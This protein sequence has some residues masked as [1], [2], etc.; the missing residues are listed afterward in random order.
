MNCTSWPRIISWH[1]PYPMFH[2][3]QPPTVFPHPICSNSSEALSCQ[4]KYWS[5]RWYL[6]KSPFFSPRPWTLEEIIF[7][8][9]ANSVRNL[10]KVLER[11]LCKFKK[12]PIFQLILKV[13][14]GLLHPHLELICHEHSFW[15]SLSQSLKL[16]QSLKEESPVCF[17]D[18]IFLNVSI[19]FNRVRTEKSWPRAREKV[20]KIVTKPDTKTN[21]I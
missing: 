6:Q 8:D 12:N 17:K 1:C 19:P 9:C 7:L 4:E 20:V 13:I 21:T 11:S 5:G 16:C 2:L 18:S 10:C 15:V 14:S 3:L